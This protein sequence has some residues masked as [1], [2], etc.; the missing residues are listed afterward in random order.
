[1]RNVV[2]SGQQSGVNLKNYARR[3][4]KI[5]LIH[6]DQ[7][8]DDQY[9][10]WKN[11]NTKKSGSL[12]M[13]L[14]RIA[15]KAFKP[16]M[17]RFRSFFLADLSLQIA[18]LSSQMAQLQGEKTKG[19][20]V[21]FG[22]GGHANVCF[23]VLTENGFVIE[24]VVV[25]DGA[26]DLDFFKGVRVVRGTQSVNQLYE[27]GLRK[28]FVAIGS[29]RTRDSLVR[30]LKQMGFELITVISKSAYVSPNVSLGK[31]T[32]VM[33]NSV[34]NSGTVIG[35]ACIVNSGSVIEHDCSIANAVHVAPG[36]VLAGNI[37]VGA[38]SFIGVGCSVLPEV[39]IGSDVIVGAGSTVLR[40]VRD[41]LKI[42]GIPAK[43]I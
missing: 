41:G 1:M 11:R 8:R 43:E 14:Y 25:A 19:S 4:S 42:A 10:M 24:A 32:I 38:R 23:E 7:D 15:I 17:Y 3:L 5:S 31:G 37:K 2:N 21:I 40:D 13:R 36:S 33:P 16:L 12:K 9:K 6:N 29:N 26:N 27:S 30:E 22:A 20:I 39:S 34:I 18:N 28:A 35:D